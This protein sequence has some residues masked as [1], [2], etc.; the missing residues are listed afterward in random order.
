MVTTITKDAV[1]KMMNLLSL[2]ALSQQGNGQTPQGVP[3]RRRLPAAPRPPPVPA[4]A[5]P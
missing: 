1:T 3:A 4:P 5:K 2:A